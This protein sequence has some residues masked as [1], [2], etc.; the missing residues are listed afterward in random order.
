MLC[1]P[2]RRRE[3]IWRNDDRVDVVQQPGYLGMESHHSVVLGLIGIHSQ[4]EDESRSQNS[5][6]ERKGYLLYEI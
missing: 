2:D 1:T 5:A 3:R 6:E 4:L